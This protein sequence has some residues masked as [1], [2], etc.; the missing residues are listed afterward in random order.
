[1]RAD[2][3]TTGESEFHCTVLTKAGGGA[4]AV[5]RVPGV[6]GGAPVFPGLRVLE[7][8]HQERLKNV[9][10]VQNNRKKL[11]KGLCCWRHMLS[12]VSPG[13]HQDNHKTQSA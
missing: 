12:T 4:P 11:F 9:N 2:R 10:S 7:F 5:E 8:G 6:G 1:M 3:I 13:S